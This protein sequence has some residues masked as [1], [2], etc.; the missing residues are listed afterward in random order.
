MSQDE[1]SKKIIEKYQEDERMMIRIFAQ[2][3]TN[4]NLDAVFLYEQAYPN[5][6]K[7]EALKEALE[8]VLPKEEASDIS[9]E[10]V[11]EVLQ[12]FGND[13]LAFVVAS[14]A[15]ERKEKR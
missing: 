10:M 1:L 8:E 15:E 13:D 11:V 2:W 5:Q 7:N 4:H 14:V 12:F 9:D 6:G 3:C